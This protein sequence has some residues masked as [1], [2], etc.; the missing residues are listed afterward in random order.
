MYG[1]SKFLRKKPHRV[2]PD[3]LLELKKQLIA[4]G[5]NPSEAEYMIRAQG[6]D[7]DFT[8]L[9][10]VELQQVIEKVREHLQLAR[11]SLQ[12]IERTP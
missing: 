1:L 8:E 4:V 12:V 5:Y 3:E 2:M 7:R 6:G 10:A 11:R 9:D